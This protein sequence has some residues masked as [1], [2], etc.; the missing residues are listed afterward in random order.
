MTLQLTLS[1]MKLLLYQAKAV[2]E[3]KSFKAGPFIKNL[4]G[5][6]IGNCTS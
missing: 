3:A 1:L 6:A 2:K 5:E 4:K